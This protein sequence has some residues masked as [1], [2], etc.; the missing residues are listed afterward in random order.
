MALPT[1]QIDYFNE[2]VNNIEIVLKKYKEFIGVKNI[3]T[4]D[5]SFIA[6]YPAITIEMDDSAEEW[7]RKPRQKKLTVVY[8]INWYFEE[9]NEKLQRTEVRS[10]LN[11][12]VN[13]LRENW[14]LNGYTKT[15]GSTVTSSTPFITNVENDV[16]V[17]G[18]IVLECNKEI[19]VT[20]VPSP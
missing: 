8:H 11:K 18:L 10:G 15:F 16:I 1:D 20:I 4:T 19:N 5:N 9:Y 12:I 7:I 6:N 14:N 17:A 2:F 3:F 13:V